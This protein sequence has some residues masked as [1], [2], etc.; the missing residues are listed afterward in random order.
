MEPDERC[1]FRQAG[2]FFENIKMFILIVFNG[3]QYVG[4]CG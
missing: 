3:S 4:Q 2:V 1:N